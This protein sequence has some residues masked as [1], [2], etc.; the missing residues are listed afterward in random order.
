MAK[1][2]KSSNQW[3]TRQKK[4]VF[5]RRAAS[6]G[7]VSRAH[8]KLEQMDQRFRLLQRGMVVLELGAAPGGW[9]RY[10]ADKIADKTDR[11]RVVAVDF[12]PITA[13]A[14]VVV[15]EG[16]AGTTQID[17]QIARELATATG[18]EPRCDLVIS[19]M[20]PN[21]TGIRAA[22]QAASMHLAELAAE[23]A[24]MYL[25]RGGHLVVKMFQGEGVD[26]WLSEQRQRFEKCQ[27]AKPKASRSESRE[28]FAVCQRF[29]GGR[30]AQP[31]TD[32]QST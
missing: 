10:V 4:D 19:D 2:T 25:K 30:I 11:G 13:P 28:V 24:A 32:N 9:T 22:D 18:S 12:R 23:A 1:R 7:L 17:A 3:M 20:A 8:F 27:F 14:S 15:I 31:D 16:E 26:E 29:K 6:E 5:A 21:I